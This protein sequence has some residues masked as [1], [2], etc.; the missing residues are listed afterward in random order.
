MVVRVS[1][2]RACKQNFEVDLVSRWIHTAGV[3]YHFSCE[4]VGDERLQKSLVENYH[5]TQNADTGQNLYCH[6]QRCL[7]VDKARTGWI[8]NAGQGPY[9]AILKPPHIF[10]FGWFF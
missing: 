3:N 1:Y 10:S 6:M 4:C 2:R 8:E 9:I 7:V 5:T